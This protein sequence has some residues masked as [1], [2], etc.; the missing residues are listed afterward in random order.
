MPIT[1][2]LGFLD[3]AGCYSV[4]F[5]VFAC[6]IATPRW[7]AAA[8]AAGK[9]PARESA[10]VG[11][12][13][14]GSQ[15]AAAGRRLAALVAVAGGCCRPSTGK[16]PGLHEQDSNRF[17]AAAS[18]VGAGRCARAPT[19]TRKPTAPVPRGVPEAVASSGS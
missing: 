12:R 18:G 5:P 17:W 16:K 14:P 10:A 11:R 6:S 4:G 19:S 1:L 8:G 15:K 3:N 13:P 7:S 2:R 9:D